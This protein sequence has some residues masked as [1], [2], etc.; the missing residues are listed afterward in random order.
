MRP[1]RRAQEGSAPRPSARQSPEDRRDLECAR[2]PVPR[3]RPASPGSATHVRRVRSR[4]G[5]RAAA[6]AAQAA[7]RAEKRPLNERE[8]IRYRQVKRT[9]KGPRP[10][11][12]DHKAT[13]QSIREVVDAKTNHG[14][15]HV[16]RLCPDAAFGR[17]SG[18]AG[19][20]RRLRSRRH[21]FMRTIHSG[22]RPHYVLHGQ[23]A[24]RPQS[25]LSCG[26]RPRRE[27]EVHTQLKRHETACAGAVERSANIQPHQTLKPR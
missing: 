12:R 26:A 10:I 14:S 18:N 24:A 4:L 5:E 22:R 25:P 7:K 8:R 2:R 11:V 9:V 6:Q 1:N 13:A 3:F 21:A 20:A 23:G 15:C 27:D 19:A 17:R 16:M